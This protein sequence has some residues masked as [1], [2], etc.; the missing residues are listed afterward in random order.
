[1]SDEYKVETGLLSRMKTA[2]LRIVM[3][4]ECVLPGQGEVH[5]NTSLQILI[6]LLQNLDL[7]LKEHVLLGLLKSRI[8]PQ[9]NLSSIGHRVQP[10]QCA[11]VC[12]RSGGG[13]GV[14]DGG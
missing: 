2:A 8:Q 9:C 13:G 7:L 14:G 3:R 12:L 5:L 6:L 4:T 11:C 1:M 10:D